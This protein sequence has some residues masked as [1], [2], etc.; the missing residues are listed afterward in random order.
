VSGLSKSS[1][2]LFGSWSVHE[3]VVIRNDV[4][5]RSQPVIC[6]KVTEHLLPFF[7]VFPYNPKDARFFGSPIDLVIFDGLSE[8]IL[9]EIVFVEIK[10]GKKSSLSWSEREVRF[11]VQEK[12]VWYSLINN[13]SQKVD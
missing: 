2:V 9:R 3:E 11:C 4:V 10:A 13:T 1:R 12:R 7:P 5:K 8:G 6:G